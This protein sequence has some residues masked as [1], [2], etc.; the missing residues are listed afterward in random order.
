MKRMLCL[1]LTTSLVLAFTLTGLAA[2]AAEGKKQQDQQKKAKQKPERQTVTGLIDSLCTKENKIVVKPQQATQQVQ[3]QSELKKQKTDAL[4]I[5]LTR[6]TKVTGVGV[7]KSDLAKGKQPEEQKQQA[8]KDDKAGQDKQQKEQ[9]VK[10]PHPIGLLAKGQ[11]VRVV[12]VAVQRKARPAKPAD[13][14]KKPGKKDRECKADQDDAKADQGK[15]DQDKAQKPKKNFKKGWPDKQDKPK[16][17]EDKQKTDQKQEVKTELRAI[18]IQIL[19]A[20]EKQEQK[21]K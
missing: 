21:A 11:T 18:T 10:K 8:K 4:T 16:Q 19:K 17:E 2:E 5:R 1:A 9:K 14:K 7:Q 13:G 12:Y 20:P 6:R 15:S 3:T